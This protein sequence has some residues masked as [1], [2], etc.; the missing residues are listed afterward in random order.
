MEFV[1]VSRA[2]ITPGGYH[3]A[4]IQFF[5]RVS[6][7]T[8]T[9]QRLYDKMIR[10]LNAA[11]IWQ[12]LD[13]LYILAAPTTAIALTNLVSSSFSGTANGS[14]TFVADQGYTGSEGSTTIFIATAL[15]PNAGGVKYVQ[16]A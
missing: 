2:V 11:G 15:D 3:P 7:L 4:S 9:R 10:G 5:Q 6:G 13:A 8:A 14:P 12:K 1:P 16:N